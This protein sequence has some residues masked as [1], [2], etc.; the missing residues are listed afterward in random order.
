MYTYIRHADSIMTNTFSM[1]SGAKDHLFIAFKIYVFLIKNKL[2]E[3]YKQL[4]PIIL[5]SYYQFAMKFSDRSSLNSIKKA[6]IN[7]INEN[8]LLEKCPHPVL[9]YII[10]DGAFTLAERIFSVK[11]SIDLRYKIITILGFR[12]KLIRY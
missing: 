3:K 4:F 6:C 10:N 1:N 2:L 5:L 11:N 12:I 9:K 7:F 8:S